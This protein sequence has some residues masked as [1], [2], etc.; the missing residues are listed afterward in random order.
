MYTLC[1]TTSDRM[2]RVCELGAY[3]WL[4]HLRR[5][6]L[7]AYLLEV[8][9][10]GLPTPLPAPLLFPALSR[11]P[12]SFPVRASFRIAPGGS[13]GDSQARAIL[14]AGHS[15]SSALSRTAARFVEG[16][17]V[18]SVLR[19]IPGTREPGN[20]QGSGCPVCFAPV[21]FEDG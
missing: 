21:D 11:P 16:L 9:V 20:F 1:Q 12:S 3:A 15:F 19:Q 10:G 2:L 4:G 14:I 13:L 18:S 5:R 6:Q 8:R 7:R 17:R